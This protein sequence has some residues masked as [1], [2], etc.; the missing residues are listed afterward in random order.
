MW[1]TYL[2]QDNFAETCMWYGKS[3]FICSH[4]SRNGGLVEFFLDDEEFAGELMDPGVVNLVLGA[5]STQRVCGW[6]E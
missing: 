5:G 2:S 1:R 6:L 4:T 3:L